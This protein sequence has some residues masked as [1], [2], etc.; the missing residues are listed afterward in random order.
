M[1]KIDALF[2]R[3]FETL[4]A[5]RTELKQSSE[6]LLNYKGNDDGDYIPLVEPSLTAPKG[7]PAPS[8]ILLNYE[9]DDDGD[10]I[11]LVEPSLTAPKGSPPLQTPIT[12]CVYKAAPAVA[13]TSEPDVSCVYKARPAFSRRSLRRTQPAT[14]TPTPAAAVNTFKDFQNKF[15]MIDATIYSGRMESKC[16]PRSEVITNAD[17]D[18][19]MALRDETK[20]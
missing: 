19:Y 13:P 3:L 9:G 2:D 20:P 7:S 15:V 11:T 14:A 1:A 18:R 6:I 12:P 17:I 8:E 10:Y 16:G 5:L 4:A